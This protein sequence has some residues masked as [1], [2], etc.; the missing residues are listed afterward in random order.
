MFSIYYTLALD[1]AGVLVLVRLTGMRMKW[2]IRIVHRL[3]SDFSSLHGIGQDTGWKG[4][5]MRGVL[6]GR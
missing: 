5:C 6:I 1:S 3:A 4:V 2:L